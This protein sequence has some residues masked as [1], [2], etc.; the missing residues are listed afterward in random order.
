MVK[1]KVVIPFSLHWPPR[2][3]PADRAKRLNKQNEEKMVNRIVKKM[4]KIRLQSG[5]FD[6]VSLFYMTLF[7]QNYNFAGVQPK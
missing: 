4:V 7:I 2:Y 1:H 5:L 3:G 6:A